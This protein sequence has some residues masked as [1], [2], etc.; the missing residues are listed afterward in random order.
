MRRTIVVATALLAL[1]AT[2]L[3]TPALAQSSFDPG[4]NSSHPSIDAEAPAVDYSPLS[5]WRPSWRLAG[6]SLVWSHAWLP[7]SLLRAPS[8]WAAPVPGDRR[9]GL[10]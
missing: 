5:A 4:H 2:V 9:W 7:A 1:L 6:L 8:M 10:R 3:V